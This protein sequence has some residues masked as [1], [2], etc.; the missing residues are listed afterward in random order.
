MKQSFQQHWPEYL[1]EAAGLGIF[2]FSAGMFATLLGYPGSPIYQSMPNAFYR[3]VLMGI[4]MGLT[5][6]GIFY[7]SW[8][9]RS[10]AHINP[11]VTLTFLRLGKVK[12]WD[13]F[14][15][16]LFQCLGGIA[17]VLLVQFILGKAFTDVPVHFVVTVPGAMGAIT[18]FWVEVLIAFLMM[19][20]VLLTS[21]HARFSKY[22]SLI[23]GVVV[24]MFVISTAPISGFS[25]NPA[26]SLA[27][28]L[29][30]NSWVSFWIYLTAPFIGMGLAAEV[31]Q[32]A[33]KKVICA[34]FHHHNHQRCIFNCGY[35]EQ[36]HSTTISTQTKVKEAVKV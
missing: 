35:M 27:S 10:G 5:A 19:S 6:L 31:Y 34:K 8:G 23:A 15:Y 14:Y 7:S 25:M 30:A 20:M 26:R 17:G 1:M 4:A 24:M 11:A 21:N 29:P 32:L 36:A 33:G 2:M 18:A 12:P 9:K 3:L 16:V 22:T 28:A 13:A